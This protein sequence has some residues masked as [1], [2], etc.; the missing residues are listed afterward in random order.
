MNFSEW[1]NSPKYDGKYK[2][3]NKTKKLLKL[4]Q[5]SN[6]ENCD[7]GATDIHHL[8]DT[9][10]QR[11]YN[12]EHYEMWGHN[13]DGTFE[14]GKYVVFW[15]HEHHAFYHDKVS[16]ESKQRRSAMLKALWQN[17]DFSNKVTKN[18][19][20]EFHWCYGKHRSEETRLKISQSLSGEKHPNYG[21]HLSDETKN[22]IS[23][24]NKGH[25]SRLGAK[26]SP[27]HNKKISEALKGRFTGENNP[28]YGK[29][30]AIKGKHHTEEAKKKISDGNKGKI[31][32]DETKEK[33]KESIHRDQVLYKQYCGPIKWNE[34]RKLLKQ[35]YSL[36]QISN[37][38][39][40]GEL[41][42]Q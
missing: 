19:S 27:E 18:R 9:E 17:E 16:E 21:K 11:K 13:L 30:P 20:G 39:Y 38:T 28:M 12:D 10:E 22:K 25:A 34:F 41:N 4:G 37:I 29:S 33:L 14:Y 42:E 1:H 26:N 36:E 23:E 2:W 24:K 5:F 40:T 3:Y 31:I 6:L 7:A 32:S 15:T 8:R 35:G